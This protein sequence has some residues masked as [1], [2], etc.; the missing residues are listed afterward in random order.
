MDYI[1]EITATPTEASET[2][3]PKLM[4]VLKSDEGKIRELLKRLQKPPVAVTKALAE[5]QAQAIAARFEQVGL[6]VR[7]KPPRQ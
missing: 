4:A 3:L 6:T 2:L 5:R 7:L 1:V